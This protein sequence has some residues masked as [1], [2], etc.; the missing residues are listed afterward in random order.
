MHLVKGSPVYLGGQLH[1]GLWLTT[2]HLAFSPQVPGHGSMHFW[3]I[4][5]LSKWH[6]ALFTHSGL[7]VGGLPIKPSTQEHTPW[8]FISLHLLLGP[9]GDGTHGLVSTGAKMRLMKEM[10][11]F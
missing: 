10:F 5:A 3:L 11:L 7:H 2:W 4:Q 6:S 8:P 1:M 9:H